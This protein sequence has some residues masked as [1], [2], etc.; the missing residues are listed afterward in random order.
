[1]YLYVFVCVQICCHQLSSRCCY[2]NYLLWCSTSRRQSQLPCI[3]LRVGAD[4]ISPSSS[5]RN[6]GIFLDADLTMR[7][8]VQRTAAGGSAALRKLRSI[9]HLFPTS[10]YQTLIVLLV[11][12]RLDY[13]NAALV[14][15]PAN[16]SHHLQSVLNA[17]ARSIAGPN[18][19]LGPH[20]QHACQLP[21]AACFR[22]HPVQIGDSDIQ[23][24]SQPCATVPR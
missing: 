14:G 3:P 9:W 1:M 12:S 21:L 5:A 19:T 7:T 6:L 16:L 17:A 18:S 10:V 20:Y 11:V 24:T 13:G 8:H 23:V 15:I 2:T 4:V 22:A